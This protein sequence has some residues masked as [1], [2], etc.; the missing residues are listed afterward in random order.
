MVKILLQQGDWKIRA[1]TRNVES[2]GA[3]A[4]AQQGVEVVAADLD[5]E[6]S[7]IKA[8]DASGV[9]EIHS[10][11]SLSNQRTNFSGC[12]S[13]VWSHKFLGTVISAGCGSSV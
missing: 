12:P 11:Y 3:K 13:C 6:N 9:S 1:I 5:D 8:F 7:L 4:L 10:P 2:R